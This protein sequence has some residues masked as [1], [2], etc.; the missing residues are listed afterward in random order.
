MALV[1]RH[2]MVTM[3]KQIPTKFPLKLF[4]KIS[5]GFTLAELITTMIIL[6]VITGIAIPTYTGSLEKMRAGEAVQILMTLQAS[7]ERYRADNGNYAGTPGGT[8][9]GAVGAKLDIAIVPQNFINPPKIYDGSAG[10]G[11][12]LAS[13]QKNDLSY[14][15]RINTAGT[16]S[17][18]P[19]GSTCDSLRFQ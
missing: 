17:C 10:A 7:Q 5:C 18:T 4:K 16:I 13:L 14:T 9:L 2:L 15:L 19:S 6:G 12:L 8:D 11:N 3:M 1:F